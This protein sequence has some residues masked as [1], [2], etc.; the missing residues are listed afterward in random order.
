MVDRSLDARDVIAVHNHGKVGEA[1]AHDLTTVIAKQRNRLKST[2]AGFFKSQNY[3]A[4]AAAGGNA[5][6]DIPGLSLS[7]QLAEE[8]CLSADVLATAVMFADSSESETAGMG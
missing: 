7:D 6:G 2:C 3:V 1:L 5:D 8:D 4:R